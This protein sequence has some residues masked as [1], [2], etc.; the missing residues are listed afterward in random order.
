MKAHIT[1][2]YG[3]LIS[4][5]LMILLEQCNKTMHNIEY[6]AY[7][8]LVYYSFFSVQNVTINGEVFQI[9]NMFKMMY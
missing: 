9:P 6:N 7:L 2:R 8:D 5:R 4:E 1:K 3:K